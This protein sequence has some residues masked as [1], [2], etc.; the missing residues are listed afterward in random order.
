MLLQNKMLYIITFFQRFS[1]S[2]TRE[3]AF[4]C[5]I[6]DYQ[7]VRKALV[8]THPSLHTGERVH[9]YTVWFNCCT[10]CLS[11]FIYV[12]YAKTVIECIFCSNASSFMN[13]DL[14]CSSGVIFEGFQRF[15]LGRRHLNVVYVITKASEKHL[16]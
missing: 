15:T 10:K 11:M 5:S 16:L 8:I 12:Q 14:H 13:F 9:L 7:G 2:H 3:K 1:K 6:C 4:E